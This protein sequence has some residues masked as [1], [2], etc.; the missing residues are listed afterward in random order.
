MAN[1][2]YH[3]VYIEINQHEFNKHL[4]ICEKTLFVNRYGKYQDFIT[5]EVGAK[6]FKSGNSKIYLSYKLGGKWNNFMTDLTKIYEEDFEDK[7]VDPSRAY[8]LFK[9]FVKFE[10]QLNIPINVVSPFTYKN[11][12]Y[13]NNRYYNCI[14]YDMNKARLSACKDLVIPDKYIGF[15]IK[16]KENEVG[17]I[18]DG[19]PIYG[20]SNIT[21]DYV[22]TCKVNEGLN[23]WYDYVVKKIPE[24]PAYWKK[25]HNYSVGML[26]RHNIFI[27]NCILFKETER[28]KSLIDEN[29]LWSTTD[30]IVSLKER[31]D[32]KI[33]NEV[34]DFKIEHQGDFAY[35]ESGYQWNMDVPKIKG[36]S[37]GKVELYNE[38]HKNKF[39]ILKKEFTYIDKVRYHMEGGYIVNEKKEKL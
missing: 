17:F 30:S 31:P 32:L 4:E 34:G 27:Y 22:F 15:G 25:V 35:T 12:K 37:K 16:P 23:K 6:Y 8:G 10:D 28:M 26:R 7:V 20:P 39:D 19:K 11:P 18:F 21:C 33:S 3:V 13:I 36:L 38:T 9:R 1:G 5:D 24:N 29:S 2:R 14:G